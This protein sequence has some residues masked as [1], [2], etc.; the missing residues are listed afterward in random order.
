MKKLVILTAMALICFTQ[1]S[2]VEAKT[3]DQKIKGKSGTSCV[4]YAITNCQ[5]TT[6][7]KI[8]R[9]CGNQGGG[10]VRDATADELSSG[11]IKFG[12]RTRNQVSG[13]IRNG[14]TCKW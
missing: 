7:L 6:V 12:N 14:K 11:L 4:A 5:N 3:C 9:K 8:C 13:L 10:N 2:S 1:A